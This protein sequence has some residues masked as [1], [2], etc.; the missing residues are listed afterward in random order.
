MFIL[1][2]LWN[3]Q[4]APQDKPF[5]P[6]KGYGKHYAAMERCEAVMKRELSADGQ[7][8]L[9]DY[10]DAIMEISILTN[11][12]SFTE[13]FRTGALMMLDVLAAEERAGR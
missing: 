10:T 8:A 11:C 9:E 1:E 13:G 4:I 7:K 3:G 12:D 5:D 2:K 6:R